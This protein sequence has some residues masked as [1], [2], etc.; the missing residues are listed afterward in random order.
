MGLGRYDFKLQTEMLTLG[1]AVIFET[2]LKV[3]LK[4]DFNVYLNR[5]V[6]LNCNNIS[7]YYLW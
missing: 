5:M 2:L 3:F 6:I 1:R 7:Q 4:L